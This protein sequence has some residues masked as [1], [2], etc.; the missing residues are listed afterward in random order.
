MTVQRAAKLEDKTRAGSES[1]LMAAAL[2][3]RFIV[4]IAEAPHPP[5]VSAINGT[6][7]IP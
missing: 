1:V 7:P 2:A 5:E 6:K 3:K 4:H